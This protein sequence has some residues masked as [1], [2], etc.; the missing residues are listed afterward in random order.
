MKIKADKIKDLEQLGFK[1]GIN[2]YNLQIDDWGKKFLRVDIQTRIIDLNSRSA[3]GTYNF[4][5]PDI[6]IKMIK[7]GWIEE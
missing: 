1:K 7:E 6:I 2:Y 3:N 5:I 4:F